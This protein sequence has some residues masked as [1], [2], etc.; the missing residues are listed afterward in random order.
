MTG[1]YPRRKGIYNE[2]QKFATYPAFASVPWNASLQSAYPWLLLPCT[3][4]PYIPL[5][6]WRNCSLFGKH[7]QECERRAWKGPCSKTAVGKCIRLSLF[8]PWALPW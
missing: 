6:Q 3:C 7:P 2:R 4:N 8:L 1:S 5:L